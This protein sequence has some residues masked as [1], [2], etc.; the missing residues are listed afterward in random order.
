M[1][2]IFSLFKED[3]ICSSR[4]GREKRPDKKKK[5]DKKEKETTS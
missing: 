1:Y 3:H 4:T 2:P 5:E